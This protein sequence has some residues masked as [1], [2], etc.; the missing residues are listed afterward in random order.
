M[1]HKVKWHVRLLRQLK[2]ITALKTPSKPQNYTDMTL[3]TC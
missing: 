2:C 3:L 1:A